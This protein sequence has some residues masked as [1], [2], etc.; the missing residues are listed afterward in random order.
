MQFTVKRGNDPC[1]MKITNVKAQRK[2][3]GTVAT[4]G[5][6]QLGVRYDHAHLQGRERNISSFNV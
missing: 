5:R 3:L 4:S 1:L 2:N 6:V